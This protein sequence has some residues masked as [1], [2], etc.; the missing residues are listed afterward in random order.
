LAADLFF[1]R[2]G[3]IS[4]AGVWALPYVYLYALQI[5]FD[6]SGYTDIALGL[7]LLFGFRWPQNFDRPYLSAS[8]QDFWRRWHITLSRFLKDYLYIS[9]GGNRHGQFRTCLNLMITMLLGGLWHGASWSFMI[10]GGLHGL[11]LIANRMWAGTWAARRLR[12][13]DNLLSAAW[14]LFCVVLTFHCVSAAWCF[15]RL[16]HWTDSVTCLAKVFEFDPATMFAGTASDVSL[17][18]L[19]ALYGVA[20]TLMRQGAQLPA[21]GAAGPGAGPGPAARGLPGGVAG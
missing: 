16:T 21:R 12:E 19:L 11:F 14:Y 17:W 1:R 8:I 18:L 10:W 5:Y 2:I 7:G 20:A 4:T 6:F 3:A 9:L 13:G 15:F